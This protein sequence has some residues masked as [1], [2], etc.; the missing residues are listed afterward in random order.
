MSGA[1]LEAHRDPRSLQRRELGPREP[2]TVVRVAPDGQR[3]AYVVG[4]EEAGI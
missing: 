1:V 4:G 2:A 3:V